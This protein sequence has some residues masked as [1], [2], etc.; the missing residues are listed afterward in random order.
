LNLKESIT[1]DSGNK[2]AEIKSIYK[3]IGSF[4]FQ[5]ENGKKYTAE[6]VFAGNVEK[7]V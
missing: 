3:G 7:K 2:V 5:P 1:D 6:A 4:V